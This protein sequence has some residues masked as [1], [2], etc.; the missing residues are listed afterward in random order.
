ML[1]PVAPHPYH[2]PSEKLTYRKALHASKG[3][4]SEIRLS[5][6]RS[7]HGYLAGIMND[8]LIFC[9]PLHGAVLIPLQ[10]L[11]Y[12]SPYPSGLA[13]YKLTPEQF[14]LRPLSLGL[15]RSFSQQLAKLE[16]EFIVAARGECPD[17]AGLL[18]SAAGPLAE[19]TDADGSPVLLHVSAIEALY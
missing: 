4:F 14:P 5:S 18:V 8:F 1:D 11:S 9:S 19:L 15:S 12:L 17:A 10:H 13:P 3:S 7:L 6:S 2:E 16:G